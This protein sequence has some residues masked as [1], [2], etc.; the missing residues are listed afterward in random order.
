MNLQKLK[1]IVRQHLEESFV[2]TKD[3]QNN[4]AKQMAG[5]WANAFNEDA[6][7][8]D[9]A[10]FGRIKKKVM[11]ECE[12]QDEIKEIIKDV[13]EIAEE[14]EIKKLAEGIQQKLKEDFDYS[15]EMPGIVQSK[16]GMYYLA[17]IEE[18]MGKKYVREIHPMTKSQNPD[19]ICKKNWQQMYAQISEQEVNENI[20]VGDFKY[21]SDP[22]KICGV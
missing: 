18:A 11:S 15:N 2:D 4:N 22:R 13:K 12:T 14:L 10:F 1:Q 20:D 17:S 9:A 19:A 16:D 6:T 5:G 7:E 21:I 3:F 8:E